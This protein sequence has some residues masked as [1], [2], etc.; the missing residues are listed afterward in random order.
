VRGGRYVRTGRARTLAQQPS[1]E[2]QFSVGGDASLSPPGTDVELC[3]ATGLGGAQR[4]TSDALLSGPIQ[5]PDVQRSTDP[6]TFGIWVDKQCPDSRRRSIDRRETGYAVSRLG[7][8][9][10][11]SR[12]VRQ[13]GSFRDA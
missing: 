12:D 6:G 1:L 10:A 9:G 5:H 11:A 2:V 3:R 7:H 8:P 13:I 4:Q